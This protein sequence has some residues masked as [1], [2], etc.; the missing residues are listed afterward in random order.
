V[1]SLVCRAFVGNGGLSLRR[2]KKIV[3]LL[4]EFPEARAVWEEIGNPEDLL[5]SMVATLSTSV[6]IPTIGAAASFSVELEREFFRLL[7]GGSGAFGAHGPD[8]YK[9]MR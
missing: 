7:S 9:I 1:E 4:R 2:S 5:I 8:V 3:Q 6:V